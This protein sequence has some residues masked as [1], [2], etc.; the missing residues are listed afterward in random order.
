MKQLA[1]SYSPRFSFS[2]FLIPLC[3]FILFSCSNSTGD[4]D[5]GPA[6]AKKFCDELNAIAAGS[7]E[8]DS[9]NSTHVN[10]IDNL[11]LNANI[12]VPAG[13][14]LIV[15]SSKAL[16][17]DTGATLTVNSGA[18]LDLTG[19]GLVLDNT[20]TL[21]VNGT[22][23]AKGNASSSSFGIVLMP[24]ETTIS[25]TINGSGI[26]HLTSPGLLLDIGARQKLTLAGTV[27]FDGLRTTADGGTDGDTMNNDGGHLVLVYGELDMQGGTIT[28]NYNTAGYDGG[29]V[30][31]KIEDKGGLGTFTMSGN[32][33]VSGNRSLR[34]GAGVSVVHGGTFI[35][36]G[37]AKVSN[38][39]SDGTGDSDSGGGGVRLNQGSDD[40]GNR[41]TTTTF[42]M[43]GNAE[44][45]GNSAAGYGGGV[46]V[47]HG[48]D[49]ILKGGTINGITSAN[50]N[51]A[52]YGNALYVDSGDG[53]AKW[54]DTSSNI[55]GGTG[56]NAPG[57]DI[58]DGGTGSTNNTLSATGP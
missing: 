30:E 13:V 25:A 12:S 17:V 36:K 16:V 18:T 40:E 23:N 24:T 41:Y 3:L 22:V 49:F 58:L 11:I 43:E 31:V 47:R 48:G 39:I 50:S 56:T 27:T 15:A 1:A 4:D 46:W 21:T 38:N 20:A 5:P 2:L 6:R 42:I 7:V 32:A 26:I 53:T 44:I 10:V 33:Q 34:G 52:R 45:S 51:A 19:G 29:G 54:G 55:S 8:V 37:N 57:S 28:G 14:A 9:Q 35:M